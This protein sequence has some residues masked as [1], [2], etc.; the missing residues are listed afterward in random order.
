MK[1]LVII[2]LSIKDEVVPHISYLDN[3]HE[4]WIV[5]KDLYES[6]RIAR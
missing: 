6:T 3:P 1:A 2:N 5:L 4:V